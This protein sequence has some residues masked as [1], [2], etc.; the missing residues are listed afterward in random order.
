M[1]QGNP[2]QSL[3]NPAAEVK[4]RSMLEAIRQATHRRLFVVVAGEK[5]NDILYMLIQH[6][7]DSIFWRI[8]VIVAKSRLYSAR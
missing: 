3:M 5:D 2:S 4:H 7:S 8:L 1:K 6:L